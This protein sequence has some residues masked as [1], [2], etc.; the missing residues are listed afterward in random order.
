MVQLATLLT[1]VT[2]ENYAARI[3]AATEVLERTTT[4]SSR[5]H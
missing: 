4:T 5:S 2:I 3:D 1:D